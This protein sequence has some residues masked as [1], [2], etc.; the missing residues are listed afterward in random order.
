M[1]SGLII[2]FDQ[3]VLSDLDLEHLEEIDDHG[4]RAINPIEIYLCNPLH[5]LDVHLAVLFYRS[6]GGF[7]IDAGPVGI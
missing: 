1:S 4:A 2:G 3:F 5:N 7:S 6:S